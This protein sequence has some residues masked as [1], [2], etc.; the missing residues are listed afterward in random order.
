MYFL[1]TFNEPEL[2]HVDKLMYQLRG[3][4]NGTILDRGRW[5]RTASL[6]KNQ[7]ILEIQQDVSDFKLEGIISIEQV[8]STFVFN[9][10]QPYNI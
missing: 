10:Q 1:V 6:P 2:P 5:V 9:A 7:W 8:N 3:Y 4:P